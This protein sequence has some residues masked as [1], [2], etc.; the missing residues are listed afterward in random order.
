MEIP[1]DEP[2]NDREWIMKLSGNVK[3]LFKKLEGK[4]GLCDRITYQDQEIKRVEDEFKKGVKDLQ[5]DY[6][7]E[8]NRINRNQQ[9]IIYLQ[10]GILILIGGRYILG[11]TS[12][13][14]VP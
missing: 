7:K 6:R 4:G 5:D 10:I 13:P 8:L 12:W 11:P 14:L 9:A 3:S 1:A 2:Q